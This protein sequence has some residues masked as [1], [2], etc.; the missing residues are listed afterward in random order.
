MAKGRFSNM[1]FGPIS[2]LLVAASLAAPALAQRPQ[3]ADDRPRDE[4]HRRN[5]AGRWQANGNRPQ[6]NAV[7]PSAQGERPLR[8][9]GP[10]AGD[11]LRRYRNLPLDQQQ[12][13]LDSDPNFRAL[14]AERQE[15]LRQALRKFGQKTPE[16]QQRILNRMEVWEHLSQEQRDRAHGIFDRLRTMPEDRR[17]Q[18]HSAF[19]ALNRMDPAERQR[20]MQSDR[21]RSSFSDE[22]RQMISDALELGVP[23]SRMKP[24]RSTPEQK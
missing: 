20:V 16:E 7:P 1:K 18:I 9:P 13:A 14:P 21:F 6:N 15:R 17:Q 19:A 8:G 2:I 4:R 10:H 24:Q 23:P 22:E 5:A 11:W 3:R 12:K